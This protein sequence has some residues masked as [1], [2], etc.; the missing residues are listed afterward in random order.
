MKQKE[1]EDLQ[2][3]QFEET[4]KEFCSQFLTD[5]NERQRQTE[6]KQQT[7]N[8]LKLKGNKYFKAKKFQ[9]AL[10]QYMEGLKLSPFD[11][12]ALLTNIAQV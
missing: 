10:E 7:A 2:N 11:G 1:E 8:T 12:T 6:K 9:E 3:K 5:M 4:N